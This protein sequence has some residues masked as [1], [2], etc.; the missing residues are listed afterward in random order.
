MTVATKTASKRYK[1]LRG[2][3]HYGSRKQGNSKIYRPGDIIE[4]NVDLNK[5]FNDPNGI[6]FRLISSGGGDGL[7]ELTVAELRKH[8]EDEEIDLQKCTAKMDVIAAIRSAS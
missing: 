3:Y 1:L 4:T 8:A 5:V 6:K 2:S 7:E